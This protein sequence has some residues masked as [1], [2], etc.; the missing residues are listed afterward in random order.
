MM[1]RTVSRNRLE[2]GFLY[3]DKFGYL[4]LISL[5]IIG[6]SCL[7]YWFLCSMPQIVYER[8]KSSKLKYLLNNRDSLCVCV[9]FKKNSQAVS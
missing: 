3:S 7:W 8:D 1:I 2:M 6:S 5:F 9:C 4:S